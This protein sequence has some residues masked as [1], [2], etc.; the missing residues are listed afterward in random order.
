MDLTVEEFAA[1]VGSSDPV[2]VVGLGT[3]A[4][5]P[6]NVRFVSAPVGI[7]WIQ[8]AEMTIQC[9]AGT[10]VNDVAEALAEHG[11]QIPFPPGGTIGGALAVGHSGIRRLA[12][13]AMRDAL[14]QTHYVGSTGKVVKAGGPT[15]KNVS[16]FDLCRLMVGSRGTL[17]FLGDVI[18]RTRPISA[19]EQWFT[20]ERD[21]WELLTG[22]FRPTS[23]LWDGAATWVLLEGHEGDVAEMAEAYGLDPIDQAPALPSGGRWSMAPS[24]LES[25]R[26][27]QPGSFIAEIGVGV[28]HHTRPRPSR[29]ADSVLAQLHARIKG[30]FD[31][32]GRLNPGVDVL[33]VI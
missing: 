22:L 12:Y 16:G 30:E 5:P 20:S 7:D 4:T 26:V 13:G 33:T 1:N 24:E 8:P 14:L 17:G 2:A 29:Q 11:Q 21:P 25:L 9:G 31:L 32:T 10:P 15:V 23:V 6:G 27:A 18:L 28:V 19:H 3:R